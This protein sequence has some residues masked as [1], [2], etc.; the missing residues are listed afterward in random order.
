MALDIIKE[1]LV[2]IGFQID[3]N[4][5]NAAQEGISSAEKTINNFNDS[6]KKGFSE[7]NDSLKDLFSILNLVSGSVGKLFP[8]LNTPFKSFIKDISVIKKLYSDLLKENVV[9]KKVVKVKTDTQNTNAPP[10]AENVTPPPKN[11]S[12]K[13]NTQITVSPVNT[14][15]ATQ[16]LVDTILKAKDATKGLALEGGTALKK[17]SIGAIASIAATV[18]AVLGFIVATKKLI[19][20]IGSLAKQD[21]EYEKLSRQLW[22]TKENAKEV[23]MALETMGATMQDLWLSPTLLKQFTQL[24]KDSAAL[25]LPK[26]YTENLKV[27]QSIG[28]EFSRL[29]Q[30]GT[31]AFQ[32]IGNYILKYAAGPLKEFKQGLS[33]FN[34]WLISSIPNIGK[35]VGSTIGLLIRLLLLLAIPIEEIFNAFSDVFNLFK[36]GMDSMP[37]PLAKVIKIIGI[38]AALI[39]A[40]PLGAVIAVIAI[41][42]DLF[43]YFKGGKSVIGGFFKVFE[44]GMGKIKDGWDYYYDKAKGTF[45]K[46]EDK[47]KKTWEKIKEYSKSLWEKGKDFVVNAAVK[48]EGFTNKVGNNMLPTSYATTN[49]NT[50]STSTANSNNQIA[51]SNT[52]KIYGS[53]DATTTAKTTASVLTGLSQRN[54]QGVY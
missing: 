47:A 2:G 48:V 19:D 22:T 28:L 11:T 13:P 26:E 45:E 17:F 21:I 15:M 34:A 7:S 54:L 5:F 43:T 6:N 16:N 32:W 51:N 49:S 52:F 29:K 44:S 8:S 46:L 39:I 31:L 12:N 18:A 30:L 24:R 1:Y 41:L 4:S 20:Y 25:K 53:K 50:N 33:S 9:K 40:G 14:S 36:T 27:V 10:Q 38:I 23:S 42:D 35:I 37:E 3:A